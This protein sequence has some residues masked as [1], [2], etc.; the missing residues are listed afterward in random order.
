MRLRPWG[1]PVIAQCATFLQRRC[2]HLWTTGDRPRRHAAESSSEVVPHARASADA[3]VERARPRPGPRL[4]SAPRRRA[5][6]SPHRCGPAP[7][8]PPDLL[9]DRLRAG[10][11]NRRRPAR[12]DRSAPGRHGHRGDDR[13]VARHRGVTQRRGSRRRGVVRPADQSHQRHA[14]SSGARGQ[15]SGACLPRRS[16][17]A[18]HR[19]LAPAARHVGQAGRRA[20]RDR[21][22]VAGPTDRCRS[23]PCPPVAGRRRDADRRRQAT[24]TGQPART[25][26]C[27]RG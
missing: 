16:L 14:A 12:P 13:G 11:V 24:R 7:R 19:G 5:H 26:T 22:C 23:G 3:H 27:C 18:G 1:D 10:R 15:R 6:R 4:A 21:P 9:R 20:A 2:D 17:T 25:S 8:T